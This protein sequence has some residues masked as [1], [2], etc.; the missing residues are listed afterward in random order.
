MEMG[1]EGANTPIF[2]TLSCSALSPPPFLDSSALV[3]F[4]SE[5]LLFPAGQ[6]LLVAG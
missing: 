2:L 1:G 6:W 4:A 5:P 3:Q